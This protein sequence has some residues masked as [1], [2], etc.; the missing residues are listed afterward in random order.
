MKTCFPLFFLLLGW[1]MLSAQETSAPILFIY[2]ASG[3]MWGQHDGKTKM[4]IATQVLGKTVDQLP[5]T[6][7]MGLIAYGHRRK[8]DCTDVEFLVPSAEGG[9]TAIKTA[10]KKIKPLG[11]TP[12]AYS[13]SLVI[14]QLKAKQ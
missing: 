14:E 1:T 8:G 10:L 3:S 9:N 5:E 11:K 2:D 12:L 6:Q 13:L 7:A 4:E